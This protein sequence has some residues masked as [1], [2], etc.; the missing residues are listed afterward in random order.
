MTRQ[1]FARSDPPQ[2]IFY[3]I[4]IFQETADENQVP[5]WAVAVDFQRAFDSV[6]H[7]CIWDALVDQGVDEGYIR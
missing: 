6:T 3:T 7:R 1:A 5:L 2:I 4:S